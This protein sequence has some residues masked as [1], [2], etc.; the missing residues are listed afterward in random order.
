M[1]E[2][3]KMG[4]E[5]LRERGLLLDHVD[6]SAQAHD[7]GVHHRQGRRYAPRL[8]QDILPRRNRSFKH[9]DDDFPC[10]ARATVTHLPSDWQ[11]PS[12]VS[13][14]KTIWS[15]SAPNA[16][17]LANPARKISIATAGFFA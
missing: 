7:D 2:R 6:N 10:L 1:A 11:K 13:C 14:E 16:A 3:Q 12:G 5:H 8:Q 15:C 9:R 17:T 4:N